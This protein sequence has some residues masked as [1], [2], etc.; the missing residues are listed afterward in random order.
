M[1]YL[2]GQVKR[3]CLM[4]HT[5]RGSVRPAQDH[6]EV[7]LAALEKMKG[8]SEADYGWLRSQDAEQRF[9]DNALKNKRICADALDACRTCNKQMDLVNRMVNSI[10]I[11]DEDVLGLK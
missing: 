3:G 8:I 5:Y 2:I 11:I 10:K 4:C 6:R 9:I 1:N 7:V